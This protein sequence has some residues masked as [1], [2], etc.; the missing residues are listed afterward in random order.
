M[1]KS[2]RVLAAG[3]AFVALA[4]GVVLSQG[5]SFDARAVARAELA[6]WVA[7]RTRG[8]DAPDQ[9]GALIADEYALYYGRPVGDLR[10][11][12]V[13]RAR[14]AVLR[15]RGGAGADWTEVERL[16]DASYVSLRSALDRR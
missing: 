1:R 14:A 5:A 10:E 15:D 6:W 2:G 3:V 13:L 8:A 7:R 4:G 12:G 16:L 11:A 9:V